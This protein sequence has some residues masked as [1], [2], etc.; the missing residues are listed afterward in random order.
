MVP[1]I[2]KKAAQNLG[3]ILS[4]CVKGMKTHLSS[5][6]NVSVRNISNPQFSS[7]SA[8]CLSVVAYSRCPGER[9]S[10]KMSAR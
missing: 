8:I 10:F 3:G 9:A 1:I 5:Y 2:M 7:M 6:P 4:R